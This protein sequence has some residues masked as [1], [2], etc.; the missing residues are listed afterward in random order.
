MTV[1]F[2]ALVHFVLVVLVG[3]VAVVVVLPLNFDFVQVVVVRIYVMYC[4]LNLLE[5]LELDVL[6]EFD[7]LPMDLKVIDHLLM[8]LL[9]DY[10]RWNR[11]NEH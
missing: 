7:C 5:S 3:M 4:D 10:Q 6:D 1:A 2:V 11:L 9:I 8:N